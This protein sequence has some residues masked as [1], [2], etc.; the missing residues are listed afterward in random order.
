MNQRINIS[1]DKNK[2]FYGGFIL[3][4]VSTAINTGY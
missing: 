1:E 3:E 4:I 2:G